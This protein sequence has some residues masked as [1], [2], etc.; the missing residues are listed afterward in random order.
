MKNMPGRRG[1]TPSPHRG[2]QAVARAATLPRSKWPGPSPITLGNARLSR[3]GFGVVPKQAFLSSPEAIQ[4][5]A[6]LGSTRSAAF[7]ATARET[8]ELT[9]FAV[10]EEDG[11]PVIT[12]IVR[13][14]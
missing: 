2:G 3:V 14:F 1:E 12:V 8:R 6:L 10:P 4:A 5:A 7:K 9:V 11:W 13:Y